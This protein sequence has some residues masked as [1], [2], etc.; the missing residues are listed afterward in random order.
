MSKGMDK[1]EK[2]LDRN[3]IN[4]FLLQELQK[5]LEL[6]EKFIEQQESHITIMS[7]AYRADA[8]QIIR[9][10]LFDQVLIDYKDMLEAEIKE[11][12]EQVNG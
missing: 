9:K 7:S 6:I 2:R 11:L 12:E 5:E 10:V 8:I 4:R 3:R 1:M